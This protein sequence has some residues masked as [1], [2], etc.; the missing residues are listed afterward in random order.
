[1]CED[2]ATELACDDDHGPGRGSLLD[3]DVE[4]GAFYLV[5]D[6]YSDPGDYQL[7]VTLDC[8]EGLV[9]DPGQ[10][11]CIAD[12][13][14]PNPCTETNRHVCVPQLPDAFACECDPG[15]VEEAGACVADPLAS[16]ETCSA[17]LA[18][19]SDTG[20]LT[21]DTSSAPQNHEGTCAGEGPE[22]IYAFTLTEPKHVD[23]IMQGYDTVAHLRSVCDAV[24][25]QL[26]CTDD[27]APNHGS[28]ITG[29]LGPGV[30]FLFVDSYDSPG[31]YTLDYTMRPD[32]CADEAAACPGTP[33]CLAN[34]DWTSYR[35][36]C[37]Q[38]ELP[39]QDTCVP[40]PCS[41]NP[42]S[43]PF[44]GRCE[45]QLPSSYTCNCDAGYRPQ[46][47]DPSVCEE[48]PDAA[49]WLVMVYLDADNNLEMFAQ[50]DIDEMIQAGHHPDVS[51][52]V[53]LDTYYSDGGT[54]RLL[55][56]DAGGT[57]ELDDWGEVDMSDW[58]TLR[59]FGVWALEA[60]PAR[61]HA[62]IL[63]DHGNGWKLAPTQSPL[64]KGFCSDDHGSPGA[65]SISNGEYASAMTPIV[66]AKGAPLELVGF[67]ACLMGM[68]EVA[69]AT[70]P[71]SQFLVASSE[72]IPGP[73]WSYDAF[74]GDLIADPSMGPETLGVSII[75]SYHAESSSNSTLAL[76]DLSTV[77]SLAV[78]ISTLADAL[79]AHPS[80]YADWDSVRAGT[81]SFSGQPFHDIGSL[82]L[83]LASMSS[84]PPDVTSAAQELTDALDLT[85]VHNAVQSGYGDSHGLS[86]YWPEQGTSMDSDY[87]ASGADWSD[88][89][90][91]D[92][93][94]TDFAG[95]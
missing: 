95:P 59:D 79:A 16:G 45:P 23:F 78:A 24:G 76:S 93:F 3:L 19:T 20:S 38:G 82:A 83:T 71:F 91:W 29:V 70:A 88:L 22:N 49:E 42:C 80:R 66:A 34:Y 64:H 65:M 54:G 61:S 67:D 5:V 9:F 57:V 37:P 90:T 68:W 73:G 21:G 92:E 72:T 10:G 17:P 27:S 55:E 75:D 94:L 30:Y 8:G 35:C 44:K 39:H 87:Q 56:V 43:E 7:R 47:S 40:D 51:V 63:W 33:E 15:F 4:A 53:L 26:A 13:C 46:P 18:L 60:Y 6:S 36:V 85:V 58:R 31:P 48:D 12:P 86:I 11:A 14:H 62:L 25:S 2:P 84:A 77:D 41:T 50:D 89:T 74:L 1:M 69:A 32:P 52:V 81:L 28:R